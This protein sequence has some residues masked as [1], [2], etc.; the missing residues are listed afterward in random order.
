MKK[1]AFMFLVGAFSLLAASAPS[2]ASNPALDAKK[3]LIAPLDR[4]RKLANAAH[5]YAEARRLQ[6]LIKQIRASPSA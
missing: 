1:V 4:L 2:L 6:D 5:N 3:A